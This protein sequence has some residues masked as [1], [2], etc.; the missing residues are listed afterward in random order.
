M[1]DGC[2]RERAISSRLAYAS[3]EETRRRVSL[4]LLLLMLAGARR[5]PSALPLSE[6]SRSSEVRARVRIH[7][8]ADKRYRQS[9]SLSRRAES[10]TSGERKQVDGTL[11]GLRCAPGRTNRSLSE[12]WPSSS[13]P[14]NQRD[15]PTITS[16]TPTSRKAGFI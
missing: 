13:P 4:L 15:A 7:P 5:R 12:L 3:E 10:S 16:S 11:C 2:E 1:G 9:Q 14:T 6:F 8:V